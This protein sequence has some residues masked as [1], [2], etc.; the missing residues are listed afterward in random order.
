M[1]VAFYKGSRPFPQCL[2]NITVRWVMNSPYSH[3]ESIFGV[4]LSKPVPCGSSSFIDGGVRVKDILLDPEHW[5][6]LD[7][8][9]FDAEQSKQ[10]FIDHAGEPYDVRG[11]ASVV[12]PMIQ[13]D[14]DRRFC[15]EAILASV[16]YPN[17]HK[18]DP[19]RLFDLCTYL[20]GARVMIPMPVF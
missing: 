16:D 11:L 1:L 2:F 12:L 19:G 14:P 7:V 17:S 3:C 6:V 15:S 10:W 9:C 18:I 20:G 4:D 5:D 8:P 13:D